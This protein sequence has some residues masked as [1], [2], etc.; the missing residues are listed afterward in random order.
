MNKIKRLVLI[1]LLGLICVVNTTYAAVKTQLPEKFIVISDIH[2]DPFL[3][4]NDSKTCLNSLENEPVTDWEAIFKKYQTQPSAIGQD[5]NYLLFSLSLVE[6]KNLITNQKPKFIM[7]LG[8]FLGHDFSWQS[9]A[10]ESC[11][12]DPSSKYRDFVKKTLTFVATQIRKVVPNSMKIYPVVGNN[13]SYT[14][15][16]STELPPKS[17]FYPDTA[18]VW[19]LFNDTATFKQQFAQ[20]GYY[21]DTLA[22][23][24]NVK[25]IAI[26]S[27]IFS[28]SNPDDMTQAAQNELAWIESQLQA[29]QKKQQHVWLIYHIPFG[30]NTYSII[31]HYI[32]I[33]FWKVN[34]RDAYV[35][36]LTKYHD[37][38]SGVLNAH[39]HQNSF[40][41]FDLGGVNFYQ[42]LNPSIS[43]SNGNNPGMTV[44]SYDPISGTLLNS[45][46][47]YY[48]NNAWQT[49]PEY[50]FDDTYGGNTINNSIDK[51][52]AVGETNAY[53]Q[54]P[55]KQYYTVL[56]KMLS[57][58]DWLDY[59]CD[60]MN[61]QESKFLDCVN[62]YKKIN[63]ALKSNLYFKL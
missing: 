62:K 60:I 44:Y 18:S 25:I 21:S 63:I 14:C 58:L 29:A 42:S 57:D 32:N 55:Y 2:F 46:T 56:A 45:T 8:D 10:G 28:R 24:S 27:N 22:A 51:F 30:I 33:R 35:K 5:S 48:Q 11:S 19:Q 49:K 3:S 12:S 6:L 23:D 1:G 59:W 15:D 16:Y 26:N 38:I 43:R 41:R 34:Y 36:L 9:V 52:I 53:D 37:V 54:F 39:T 20:A 17:R 47:Y 7:I 40:S 61:Y 31:H 50:S 4:C 13:D